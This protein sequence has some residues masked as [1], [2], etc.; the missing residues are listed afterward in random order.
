M[1]TIE[2]EI[3]YVAY[4]TTLVEHE[5]LSINQDTYPPTVKLANGETL[6]LNTSDNLSGDSIDEIIVIRPDKNSLSPSFKE[7]EVAATIILKEEE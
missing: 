2:I 7:N 5:V 6:D 3:K 1:S 4:V